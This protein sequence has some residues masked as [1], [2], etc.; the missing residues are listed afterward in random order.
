MSFSLLNYTFPHNRYTSLIPMHFT[1]LFLFKSDCK[2]DLAIYNCQWIRGYTKQLQKRWWRDCLYQ[3]GCLWTSIC[4]DSLL[5]TPSAQGVF[6]CVHNSSQLSLQQSTVWLWVHISTAINHL[7]MV[8]MTTEDLF[9]AQLYSESKRGLS[10]KC[11]LISLL[12]I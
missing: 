3:C 10:C 8:P 1:S 11:M 5:A 7:M 9:V 6:S 2:G 12:E 4:K